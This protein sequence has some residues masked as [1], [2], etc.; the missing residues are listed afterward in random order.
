MNDPYK[1]LEFSFLNDSKESMDAKL[2]W[3]ENYRHNG[4]AFLHPQG[5]S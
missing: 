1:K 5:P 3:I 2:I 4:T